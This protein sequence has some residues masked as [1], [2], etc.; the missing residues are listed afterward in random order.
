MKIVY[1]ACI[2]LLYLPNLAQ[3][4]VRDCPKE[5]LNEEGHMAQ[6]LCAINVL[7]SAEKELQKYINMSKQDFKGDFEGNQKYIKN[8]ELAHK[9]WLKFR[10][11]A[12]EA[13]SETWGA[14]TGRALATVTCEIDYT[15]RWTHMI[16]EYFSPG[17]SKGEWPE[18]KV[19]GD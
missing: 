4:A 1:L 14:G 12:C 16:W 6:E 7:H 13:V 3:G 11:A 18:P 17:P 19:G 8:I 10:K 9:E 5:C 15:R 2:G